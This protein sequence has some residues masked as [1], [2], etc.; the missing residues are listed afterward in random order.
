MSG[1]CVEC[2]G[3]CKRF[4]CTTYKAWHNEP[5][6]PYGQP[7]ITNPNEALHTKI[8]EAGGIVHRDGN[9]FF[10]GVEQFLKASRSATSEQSALERLKT[11]L[12]DEDNEPPI[13]RLRFFCCLAMSGQDWQDVEPFFDAVVAQLQASATSSC[14]R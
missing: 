6:K 14:G 2:G 8:R 13:E 7:M 9:I 4:E 3:G 10:T 5:T 12:L 1:D 11:R